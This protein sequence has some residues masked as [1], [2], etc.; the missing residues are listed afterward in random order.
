MQ[1]VPPNADFLFLDYLLLG[2]SVLCL[3]QDGRAI[4]MAMCTFDFGRCCLCVVE[5]GLVFVLRLCCVVSSTRPLPCPSCVP[6]SS[7][8]VEVF[9]VG[10]CFASLL[11]SSLRFSSHLISSL[12]FSSLLFSSY[13]FSSLLFSSHLFSSLRFSSP[14]FSSFLF[15][16]LIVSY[17]ILSSLLFASLLFSALL[18]SSLLLSF[19]LF[20][21]ACPVPSSSCVP[22]ASALVEVCCVAN[23]PFARDL[24]CCWC[25]LPLSAYFPKGSNVDAKC[26]HCSENT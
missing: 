14:L 8:L 23:R 10:S 12:L 4:I 11:F 7:A 18:F 17:L 19:L 21:S 22:S 26:N 9:C 15:S 24:S 13:L 3:T 5:A 16:S 20:C 6:S 2:S 1:C 25:S